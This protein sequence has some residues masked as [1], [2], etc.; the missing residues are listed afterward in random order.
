LS[1]L[2]FAGLVFL[3]AACAHPPCEPTR[4]LY[5][6]SHAW[7][8]GIVVE[9][10]E[11]VKRLPGL[12]LGEGSL[13]EVGWG[14]ERFYPARETTLGMALRAALRPNASVLQVVPFAGAPRRYFAGAQVAEVRT[15]EAGYAAALERVAATF[16]PPFAPLGPS[17]YGNGSF[18]R[19][20]GSFHL[21]NNCNTWV[22]DV[23]AK[24]QCER[25][26]RATRPPPSRGRSSRLPPWARATR[27]T[28]ASP[29][30]APRPPLRAASS[31]VKGRFTRSVS[32]GGMPGPRS[33][34]SI[35]APRALLRSSISTGSPA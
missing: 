33:R 1:G 14:E 15:D 25:D 9:R 29:R 2:A 21:F 4:T 8:S 17:L 3:L 30:P 11:L 34:T 5:I 28:I 19:A 32:C 16:K 31:R 7:H 12:E 26:R 24:A 27:S 23:L 13:V 18:Y 22:R 6:V 10:A 20:E 35:T